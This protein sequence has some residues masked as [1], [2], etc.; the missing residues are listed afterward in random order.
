MQSRKP[1][2]EVTYATIL[3]I[4]FAI[5][6]LLMAFPGTGWLARYQLKLLT[7]RPTGLIQILKDI[8]VKDLQGV[9]L[10]TKPEKEIL[11]RAAIDNSYEE[12]LS[13]ALASPSDA[14][15]GLTLALANRSTGSERA[16]ALA[17]VL[18]LETRGTIHLRR[19][20]EVSAYWGEPASPYKT[21]AKEIPAEDLALFDQTAK[22]GERLDPDNAYFS[23]MRAIGQIAAHR[24][25]EGLDEI[26][27]AG[28]KPRYEDYA[29]NESKYRLTHVERRSGRQLSFE[30]AMI[31][32]SVLYPHYSQLRA[33]ARFASYKADQ[34]ERSDRHVDGYPLR[35]AMMRCGSLMRAQSRSYIGSLVGIAIVPIAMRTKESVNGGMEATEWKALTQEQQAKR[36]EELDI[37][38]LKRNGHANEIPW[39]TY[40]LDAGSQAR[41]IGKQGI[42]LGPLGNNFLAELLVTGGSAIV[43]LAN[44]IELILLCALMW[45]L[46]GNRSAEKIGVFVLSL[47]FLFVCI[48]MQWA[49]ALAGIHQVIVN[50]SGDD[51]ANNVSG[52]QQFLSNLLISSPVVARGAAIVACLLGPVFTLCFLGL[53]R[54]ARGKQEE[55]VLASGLRK[56]GAV[57]SLVFVGLYVVAFTGALRLENRQRAAQQKMIE[58]EGSYYAEVVGKPWPK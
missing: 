33:M 50:L 26:R 49:P 14:Q 29:M 8:G 43:L 30:T 25:A 7:N 45:L 34:E 37:A 19:D 57:L 38:Y 35:R 13:Q 36:R 12:Q 20:D 47:L 22:E 54:I 44:G 27:L 21:T 39:L 42:M 58:G 11:D 18:R 41:D 1:N 16:E 4:A 52:T 53:M 48:R 5:L 10:D 28:S 2:S 32:G 23:M 15:V 3:G 40:E 6:L 17:H 51:A 46:K 31:M 9:D 56:G 24:D 55:S